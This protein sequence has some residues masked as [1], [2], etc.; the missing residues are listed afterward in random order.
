MMRGLWFFCLGWV[1]IKE[2]ICFAL[3]SEFNMRC[4]IPRIR[5]YL[6]IINLLTVPILSLNV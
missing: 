5:S 1:V 2:V 4:L 3:E 6:Y